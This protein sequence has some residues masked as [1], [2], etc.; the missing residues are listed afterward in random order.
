[1]F[2]VKYTIEFLTGTQ[3]GNR[4][5]CFTECKSMK[6]A[7]NT[8]NKELNAK[9]TKLISFESCLDIDLGI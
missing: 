2:G 8:I 1:M 5:D 7:L 4:L 3:K 6:A 9:R